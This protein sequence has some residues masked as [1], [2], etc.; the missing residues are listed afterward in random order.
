MPRVSVVVPAYQEGAGIEDVI[1]R[2]LE[3]VTLPCEIV[4]VVDSPDDSTV[5]YVD[6]YARIDD[7][8]R[9]LGQ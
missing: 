9:V 6:K 8:I 3:A 4:V 7:R 1:R 2:L 5:P